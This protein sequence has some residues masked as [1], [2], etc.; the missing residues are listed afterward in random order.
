MNTVLSRRV[1]LIPARRLPTILSP[2]IGGA[3][4]GSPGCP[5]IRLRAYRPR[6]RLRRFPSRLARVH[7]PNRV[8]LVP[9]CRDLVTD[10]SFSFRCSPPRLAATQLRFDTPRLFA[11]GKRTSTVRSARHLRRTGSARAASTP[12]A[13]SGRKGR[14]IGGATARRRDGSQREPFHLLDRHFQSHPMLG[15]T[16]TNA[17]RLCMN[18]G[19]LHTFRCPGPEPQSLAM[20]V[21]TR[22]KRAKTKIP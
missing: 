2:T 1:S 19:R 20:P 14:A 9:V 6:Y 15:K 17:G 5:A 21:S 10:W 22:C 12:P 3:T 7:R 16:S 18:T 11:A 8:H 4:G 13:S